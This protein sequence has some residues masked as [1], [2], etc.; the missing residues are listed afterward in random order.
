MGGC[1]CVCVRVHTC[2]HSCIPYGLCLSTG[3][4]LLVVDEF[5]MTTGFRLVVFTIHWTLALQL[6]LSIASLPLCPTHTTMI[7]PKSIYIYIWAQFSSVHLNRWPWA[8]CSLRVDPA[9]CAWFQTLLHPVAAHT[10]Q[11]LREGGWAQNSHSM[12]S[13]PPS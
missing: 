3:G 5:H 2:T 8:H 13:K 9:M 7:H 6:Q 11:L 10:A 4:C 12:G 1:V